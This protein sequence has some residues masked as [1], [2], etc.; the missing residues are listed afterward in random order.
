[1]DRW[2]DVLTSSVFGLLR[3]LPDPVLLDFL[4]CARR[5]D[6]SRLET[7]ELNDCIPDTEFWPSRPGWHRE[8]D[9]VLR[10]HKANGSMI[11]E[12]VVEAKYLSGKSGEAESNGDP[13]ASDEVGGCVPGDQLADELM[14]A[15][16]DWI[17]RAVPGE[18]PPILIYLTAGFTM[19]DEAIRCS[20]DALRR[21]E[22]KNEVF[23]LGWWMLDE[24]LRAADLSPSGHVVAEDLRLLLHRRGQ[25]LLHNAWPCR[26]PSL[27]LWSFFPQP[28]AI[29]SD[30]K[31]PWWQVAIPVLT[32]RPWNL[33]LE[34]RKF[35]WHQG[36]R[37]T[38]SPWRF[39][40]D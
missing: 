25:R 21:K 28:A 19:P 38:S 23:W 29:R 5:L 31:G 11:Q 36:F 35:Q 16:S 14:L 1:M 13:L 26:L 4:G 30:T 20:V 12:I 7:I 33:K 34:P 2:E 17:S 39:G 27:T 6:G 40:N 3:Y 8:P 32:H 9:V 24:V 22:A 37:T 15:R 18:Y 10:F